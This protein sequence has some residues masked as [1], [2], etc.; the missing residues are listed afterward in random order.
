MVKDNEGVGECF[1]NWVLLSDE[2]VGLA[3]KDVDLRNLPASPTKKRQSVDKLLDAPPA[4]KSKAEVMD[5]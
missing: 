5:E 4:K 2:V 1:K 3:E